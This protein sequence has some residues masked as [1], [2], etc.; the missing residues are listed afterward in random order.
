MVRDWF[1]LRSQRRTVISTRERPDDDAGPTAASSATLTLVWNEGNHDK[2]M[3][4]QPQA[5]YSSGPVL[6]FLL[7]YRK[8]CGSK[9]ESI[10]E[11]IARSSSG[12]DQRMWVE[13]GC[14]RSCFSGNAFLILP[15]TLPL[16]TSSVHV[17]PLLI[18]DILRGRACGGLNLALVSLSREKG[19]RMVNSIQSHWL[20]C[21]EMGW[22]SWYLASGE[23]EEKTTVYN[24]CLG[25]R[26]KLQ[27]T[28]AENRA[29]RLTSW[30]IGLFSVRSVPQRRS[31]WR[32][33]AL[34][35]L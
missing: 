14:K 15:P 18:K 29:V 21:W 20:S 6:H 11:G 32:P 2:V 13:L 26:W 33:R 34:F 5:H 3:L 8:V 19:L 17:C 23:W 27:S 30:L 31:N 28:L 12:N 35:C 25:C 22:E 9:C 7:V 1:S 10:V 16:I 4:H 24:L